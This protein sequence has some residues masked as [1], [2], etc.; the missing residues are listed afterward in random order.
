MVLHKTIFWMR[1]I[2][3]LPYED[4]RK[5]EEGFEGSH[6]VFKCHHFRHGHLLMKVAYQSIMVSDD[7]IKAIGC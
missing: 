6:N 7:I 5:Q 2:F 1:A 4:G 3:H